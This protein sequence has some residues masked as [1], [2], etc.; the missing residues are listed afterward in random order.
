MK[1][2]LLTIGEIKNF[3]QRFIVSQPMK[4]RNILRFF[5]TDTLFSAD[6]NVSAEEEG[7]PIFACFVLDYYCPMHSTE[8]SVKY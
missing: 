5:T 4:N 7:L 3:P 2:K 8:H 1:R 6:E